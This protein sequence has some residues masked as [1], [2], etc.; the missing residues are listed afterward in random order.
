MNRRIFL[1]SAGYVIIYTLIG[2]EF[3]W[4]GQGKFC[5]DKDN[6][7]LLA[8]YLQISDITIKTLFARPKQVFIYKTTFPVH[9]RP[10]ELLCDLS[11]IIM[12]KEG[13]KIYL[14]VLDKDKKEV[15]NFE[16]A[17]DE[18]TNYITVLLP[19]FEEFREY[20][21]GVFRIKKEH[22]FQLSFTLADETP[23]VPR[24]SIIDLFR[25]F[26]DNDIKR[27]DGSA[28]DVAFLYND[29]QNR[30]TFEAHNMLELQAFLGYVFLPTPPP[31]TPA[32][33][34]FLFEPQMDIDSE[35]IPS[36]S[37]SMYHLMVKAYTPDYKKD[38]GKPALIIEQSI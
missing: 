15:L 36:T 7:D 30:P 10:L 27:K 16:Q 13:I 4:A 17:L 38:E 20:K 22:Y 25:K 1:K 5:P 21:H 9:I 31:K 6:I 26:F 3:A 35:P 14:K 19:Y 8:P 11:R 12:E 18:M 33:T 34:T 29:V 37:W 23:V 28:I 2:L 24:R 32:R